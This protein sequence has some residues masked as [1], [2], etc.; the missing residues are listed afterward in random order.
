MP[1]KFNGLSTQQWK[2][3]EAFMPAKPVKRGRGKP[4]APFRK[5]LNTILY[6]LITGCRWCDV[7]RGAKWGAR[8]TAHRWLGIWQ[9]DGTYRKLKAMILG[10]AELAGL[11]DWSN[12][13]GDGSYAPGKG[14]GE[15]VDHGFKGKGVLTHAIVDGNGL[16]LGISHTGAA[17]NERGEIEPIL[18]SID[19]ETGRCGR[20]KSR[21]KSLELDKGYDSSELRK[22]N[23]GFGNLTKDS[24][25]RMEGPQKEAW[26]KGR[27]A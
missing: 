11:I 7:P 21:P 9:Q 8:S 4:P 18:H 27:A 15:G 14:G 2:L 20:R 25:A 24:T 10:A 6:V 26:K 5:I 1:G 22:K 3:F 16:P 17:G 19:V 12:A 23:P 13:S